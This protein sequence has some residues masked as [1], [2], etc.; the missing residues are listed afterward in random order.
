M[1]R[2]LKKITIALIAV[3]L[4]IP[5]VS[6][7]RVFPLHCTQKIKF[8]VGYEGH[9]PGAWVGTVQ[10]PTSPSGTYDIIF[11]ADPLP[12][13]FGP[14][15]TEPFEFPGSIEVFREEWEII[16]PTTEEVLARGYDEGYFDLDTAKWKVYGV[17]EEVLEDG[18]LDFL[19]GMTLRATGKVRVRNDMFHGSGMIKFYEVS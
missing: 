16:H 5:I 8:I 12:T 7:Q 3:I 19:L 17:V 14:P 15:V 13:F 9:S 10:I 2:H 6:A 11:W 1:K 18:E 4:I